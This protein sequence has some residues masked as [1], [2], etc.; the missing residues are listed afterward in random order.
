MARPATG[1]VVKNP[2]RDGITYALR[3]SYR[4]QREYVTLGRP[5]EGWT[6][7]RAE[8]ELANVMADV[9]RGTWEPAKPERAPRETPTFHEFASEWLEGRKGELQARTVEDYRWTLSYHLLPFFKDFRLDEITVQAVDQYK[10]RK[11]A[12]GKIAPAQVNKTLKHLAQIMDAAI[13]YELVDRANPARGRRRRVKAPK[14][15]RTWVE[16]E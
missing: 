5:E 16:P 14:P 4:G 11:M 6:R 1:C 9:R 8:V 10:A 3:F 7:E 13:E 2:T 12:E 15:R